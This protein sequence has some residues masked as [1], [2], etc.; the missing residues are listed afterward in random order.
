MKSR[1]PYPSPHRGERRDQ[2]LGRVEHVT[3]MAFDR[4]LAAGWHV[5][6]RQVREREGNR[7]DKTMGIRVGWHE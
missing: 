6:R 2:R 1:K 5:E 3:H 7:R 4:D